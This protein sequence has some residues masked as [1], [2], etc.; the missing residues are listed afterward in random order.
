MSQMKCICGNE[1][2]L[3][4]G[5]YGNYFYCIRCG[6]IN[7]KKALEINDVKDEG[8]KEQPKKTEIFIRSDD[9]RFF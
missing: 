3:K 6:N 7:L 1:L 2:E 9:P 4:S 8:K 5:K